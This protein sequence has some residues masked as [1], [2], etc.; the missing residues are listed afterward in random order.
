MNVAWREYP[1]ER[2]KV[3]SIRLVSQHNGDLSFRAGC[4]ENTFAGYFGNTRH[5][6]WGK[7]VFI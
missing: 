6:Q 2:C 3:S 7:K 5:I 4:A 1:G